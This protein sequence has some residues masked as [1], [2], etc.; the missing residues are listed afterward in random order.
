MPTLVNRTKTHLVFNIPCPR[1]CAR[2]SCTCHEREITS[3]E[4]APDGTRG[5]LVSTK[6]INGSVTLLAKE[7]KEVPDHVAS[8]PEVKRAID[9]G[10]LRLL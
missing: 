8:A 7:R 1:D 4:S 2:K 5:V 3:I 10:S 9:Q 6:R